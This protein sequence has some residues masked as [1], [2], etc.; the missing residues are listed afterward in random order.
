MDQVLSLK[1]ATP[2]VIC[3]SPCEKITD[4]YMQNVQ[5]SQIKWTLSEV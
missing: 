3:T 4:W 5:Y 1:I 2:T